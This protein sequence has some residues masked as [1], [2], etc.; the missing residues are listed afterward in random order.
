MKSHP[1]SPRI[2]IVTPEI[3]YLPKEMGAK[4]DSLRAK[5]G[6]LADVSAALVKALFDQGAD[7]HIALPNYRAIF[8]NGVPEPVE[9]SLSRIESI[10]ERRIHLAEDWA[11]FYQ[12]SVYSPY[13]DEN[14]RISLAFQ[15]EVMNNIVRDVQ[16]DIIHCND[17][18]TGLIP[19]MARQREI[20][21][22]FTIHNIHTLVRT[23]GFIEDRGIDAAS[24]WRH[25]YFKKMVHNYEEARDRVGVD[26]LASGVFAAHFV[27]T[28]STTF[29]YEMTEGRHA[30]VEPP[31][32]EE[33]ANKLNAGCAFGILNAPDPT[34]DPKTDGDLY[35]PYDS[36]THD[37]AKRINKRKFQEAQGLNVDENAPVFFWP[38]R[39]DSVQKGCQL[40][41]EILY[42]VVSRYW[43]Q[44]LQIVFVATGEYKPHF[45]DIVRFHDLGGRVAIREFDEALARQAFAAADFVLMPSKF[46][47]CGLPQMIG[48]I[49][50][51]LPVAHATGGIR[52]TV[53]HMD[54]HNNK[55]NGFL[56]EIFDAEGLAWAMDQAMWFY[57]L[58]RDVKKKQIKRVMLHAAATFNHEVTAQSYIDLYEKMLH[59][60]LLP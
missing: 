4:A 18:T 53:S 34:F 23:M 14:A 11:F 30:F 44:N 47:P 52:D 56:F 13:S 57:N 60:P 33:L 39:L 58:P 41:A 38:S 10:G 36:D 8:N 28:V 2:L 25:L 55:G 21:C 24:F 22:L 54:S 19:A 37:E 16:P 46:E 17:W 35:H 48:P 51:V 5:A 31:L 42:K 43:E 59:R 50:G 26:L 32:R 27:N 40:L 7:V 45:E 29:L 9:K 3:T 15:R 6:G 12:K 49:Y 20:P 1:R